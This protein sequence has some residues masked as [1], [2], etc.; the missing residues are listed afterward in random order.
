MTALS[1]IARSLIGR[2]PASI[3]KRSESGVTFDIDCFSHSKLLTLQTNPTR[4]GSKTKHLFVCKG[5]LGKAK[6]PDLC[7][8]PERVDL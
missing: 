3:A 2:D 1:L 7:R 8:S 6:V 5:E 4:T